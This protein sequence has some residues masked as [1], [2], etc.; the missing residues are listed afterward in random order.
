MTLVDDLAEILVDLS[1]RAG[2]DPLD[3]LDL[4]ERGADEEQI[5]A[6]IVDEAGPSDE[7]AAFLVD[8]VEEFVV[9]DI[10]Q[11]GELTPENVQAVNDEAEGN[12]MLALSSVIAASMLVE[13]VSAGQIDETMGQITAALAGLG[14]DD[15]TG[16]ELTARYEQGVLPALEA[17]M[18]KEHVPQFVDLA[19]AVEFAL[20][21][22]ETDD[23]WL[24]ASGASPEAIDRIG[25]VT[26]VDQ[27]NLLEEWGIRPDQ[28]PILEEVGIKVLEAEELLETPV[29]FGVIPPR[30]VVERELARGGLAEDTK[31]LF[32]DVVESI[33]QATTTWEE[34]TRYEELVNLLDEAADS[35]ELDPQSV[36][37]LFAD[38]DDRVVDELVER[39]ELQS[40]VPNKAP[41]RS[42]V[43]G[44][45]AWGLTDI[46]TLEQRYEQVDVD[47][48]K[49]DDIVEAGILDEIDGD[50]QTA[51][52]LGN[53][54]AGEYGQLMDRVGLSNEAQETLMTGGDLGDVTERVLEERADPA[55]L[56]VESISGIGDA[57]GAGLRAAGIETVGDLATADTQT[58]ADAAQVDQQT[59]QG[60]IDQ[61]QLRVS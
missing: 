40:E 15:V 12:A 37:P 43:D 50:L 10:V 33:P 35:G 17:Q 6:A 26:P 51:F 56:P 55:D 11:A 23:E 46:D 32:L 36:R 52:A 27:N 14:V 29:E 3:V 59:A 61:A 18:A 41:T 20:R 39:F 58:V 47:P 1:R 5:L 53:L 19:D 25:S 16:A 8:S 57:R 38:L 9:T 30:D 42:Q 44:S 54:T 31:Q 49:Y 48:S 60:F 22:K 34:R 45:F 7:L 24:R 13:T 4:I 28:L 21:T 2:V